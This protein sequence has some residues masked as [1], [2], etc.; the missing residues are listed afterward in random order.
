[1]PPR[2]SLQEAGGCPD[3]SPHTSHWASRSHG[4]PAFQA[5][6]Q[7][8]PRG[9]R[10]CVCP[11]HSLPCSPLP[12][13]T[14]L[15]PAPALAEP[16]GTEHPGDP[17][18]ESCP[19]CGGWELWTWRG[20]YS[21][22]SR[23][24]GVT[25]LCPRIQEAGGLLPGGR[26]CFGTPRPGGQA[27][28]SHVLPESRASE[29]YGHTRWA[30]GGPARGSRTAEGPV[31]TDGGWL[32]RPRCVH[33]MQQCH[34][35]LRRDH[36][37]TPAT[38]WPDLENAG[39]SERRHS[40]KDSKPRVKFTETGSKGVGAQGQDEGPWA[41]PAVVPHWRA[42]HT[43]VTHAA[44]LPLM[45]NE[46]PEGR[47]P[48]GALPPTCTAWAGEGSGKHPR[49]PGG[50]SGFSASLNGQGVPPRRS[51]FPWKGLPI[52]ERRDKTRHH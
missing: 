35:A 8:Q 24:A 40:Q 51:T 29:R 45:T 47:C 33:G 21:A 27:T 17:R 5:A 15:G 2:Q 41:R 42:P 43:R 14:R 11:R 34:S 10:S 18:K 31:H 32:R 1:M 50:G 37:L 26:L 16:T 22:G 7:S 23:Q 20:S 36:V 44:P 30:G 38:T 46:H 28:A 13:S 39:K 25:L 49:G 48:A 4:Q 52:I 6:R 9:F 3:P 19:P 12:P